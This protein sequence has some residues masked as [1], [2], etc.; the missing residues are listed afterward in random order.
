MFDEDLKFALNRSPHRV[1]RI[2]CL[3]HIQ[4]RHRC[5]VD[6]L[7][8]NCTICGHAAHSVEHLQNVFGLLVRLEG[9]RQLRSVHFVE[10]TANHSNKALTPTLREV[11][12]FLGTERDRQ[13]DSL[14]AVLALGL[15]RSCHPTNQFQLRSK[16]YAIRYRSDRHLCNRG[17]ATSDVQI[18]RH[19]A[20]EPAHCNARKQRGCCNVVGIRVASYRNCVAAAR[21]DE[22]SIHGTSPD[23][24]WL[25]GVSDRVGVEDWMVLRGTSQFRQP[26]A[27]H[28]GKHVRLWL[29]VI[30]KPTCNL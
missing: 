29:E 23:E 26:E 15:I 13:A 19:L 21:D 14:S 10:V 8:G 17:A 2:F 16:F 5:L 30:A 22:N 9:I 4:D 25:F 28:L 20:L 1:C 3:R 7:L 27:H 12:Q 24:M 11:R 18:V 6:C